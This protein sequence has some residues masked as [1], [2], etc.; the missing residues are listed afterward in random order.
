MPRWCS[1]QQLEDGTCDA[2]SAEDEGEGEVSGCT[3]L[4]LDG[5]EVKVE[6]LPE[7]YSLI[8]RYL[9]IVLS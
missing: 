4:D 6:C 8:M 9:L 5:Q 1:G 7:G 2:A 3:K